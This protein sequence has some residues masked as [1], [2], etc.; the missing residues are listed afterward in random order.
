MK[1]TIFFIFIFSFNS[2]FCQTQWWAEQN[3]GVTTTL[4]SVSVSGGV[5]ACG[6]S[7]VVLRTTNGGTN[8]I[9]VSGGGIPN[10]V[11]LINILGI[12]FNTALVAG[13]V[14]T[15]NTWVWK[16][17]NAGVNWV[18]VFNQ[19]NGFIDA[20]TK[21]G[22]NTGKLIMV[23]DPVGGRWSIW[24]STNLGSSWD[25]TGM[26][27]P[28]NGTE[29]G[30]NNALYWNYS[31]YVNPDSSIWFGTNNFRIY[32]STNNGSSWIAQSTGATE[33]IRHKWHVG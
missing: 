33:F 11:Q 12:D 20:I 15:T 13:Y 14:G 32:R 1:L 30:Y 28:Q 3:S 2:L 22:S 9:N 4:T 19:P 24:K 31:P 10:N 17:T 23:G 26:Y 8:W 7:G 21:R 27:L 29:T 5:W 6:Y 18:Q 16:T 25:S